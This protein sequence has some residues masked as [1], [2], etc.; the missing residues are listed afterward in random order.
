MAVILQTAKCHHNQG[1]DS[2]GQGD[3]WEPGI[4]TV[5]K[6]R[7]VFLFLCSWTNYDYALQVYCCLYTI[8]QLWVR[9]YCLAGCWKLSLNTQSY[10]DRVIEKLGLV[11]R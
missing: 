9:R 2:L 3:T 4:I 7:Y 5:T 11:S 10:K 8:F 6:K 1:T